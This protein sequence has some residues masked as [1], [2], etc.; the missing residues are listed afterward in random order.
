MLVNWTV[1]CVNRCLVILTGMNFGD[2]YQ[3]RHELDASIRLNVVVVS[4][5]QTGGVGSKA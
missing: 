2:S 5:Q 3:L 4:S 1:H